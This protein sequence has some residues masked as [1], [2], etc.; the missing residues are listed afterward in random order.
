MFGWLNN[1]ISILLVGCRC[2]NLR[3]LEFHCL[4]L[5]IDIRMHSDFDPVL[6]AAFERDNSNVPLQKI[7]WNLKNDVHRSI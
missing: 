2:M 1:M 4:I 3:F 5:I 6:R 7:R